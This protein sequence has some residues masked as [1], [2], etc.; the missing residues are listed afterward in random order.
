LHATVVIPQQT[1]A[2]YHEM[3]AMLLA[4]IDDVRS[5]LT[6]Q[7]PLP[8]LRQLVSAH[9]RWRL[10]RPEIAQA[11]DIALGPRT[12][13][14]ELP[15]EHRRRVRAIKRMYMD[16]LK[17]VL[18][19]GAKAGTFDYPDLRVTT[20]AILSL[21]GSSHTWYDPDGDLTPQQVAAMYADLAA[22]MVR[23]PQRLQEL[24]A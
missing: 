21:C 13:V 8:R 23:A 10:E 6:A 15:E 7:E 5:E 18:K 9:V 11:L 24:H 2:D 19:A 14:N 3:E 17:C 4:F 1:D 16:E 12:R 20:F 22:G